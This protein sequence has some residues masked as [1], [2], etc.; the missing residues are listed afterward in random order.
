MFRAFS[1]ELR[2]TEP[3]T[4]LTAPRNSP[5]NAETTASPWPRIYCKARSALAA[6]ESLSGKAARSSDSCAITG[7]SPWH[8]DVNTT[9]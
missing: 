8:R 2:P 7:R 4:P 3:R 1:G 9:R 5:E 6:R